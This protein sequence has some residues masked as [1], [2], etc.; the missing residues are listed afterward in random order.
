MQ[1]LIS[2]LEGII[3]FVSPCLLPLLPV[4]ISFFVGGEAEAG[5]MKTLRGAAGFVVG[6]TS[7]F[8]LM[9]AFA[10]LAGG[11][12]RAHHA[13]INTI[14]GTIIIFFGLYAVGAVQALFR[15]RAIAGLR[16]RF[17]S[18]PSGRNLLSHKAS[19]ANT[20]LFSALLFGS[21]FAITW[22]PCV[23]VFLGSALMLASRQGS[24]GEGVA[25]LL[26]YC[27]GLGLPF[28]L[29]AV[30]LEQVKAA[31]SLINRH[32]QVINIVSGVFLIFI[33]TLIITGLFE[34]G[35]I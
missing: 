29:C 17:A 13:T 5:K 28:L 8:T 23:G 22:T 9:G 2:F 21:V 30:L 16:L 4:Y 18:R 35:S 20:N 3:T 6:F 34:G 19:S 7:V 15:L 1:Y 11:L 12:L 24:A 10:G 14:T 27:L 25:M 33:G 32:Y 31:F 26:C